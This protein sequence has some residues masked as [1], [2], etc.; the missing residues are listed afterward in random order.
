MNRAE[1]WRGLRA[2]RADP[3]GLAGRQDRRPVFAAAME[4]AEQLFKSAETVGPA[5]RPLNLFYALSQGGRALAAA[6]QADQARWR[7]QSHG[8]T[9]GP[10]RLE[11]AFADLSL[12]DQPG[13]AGSFNTVAATLGSPSLMAPTRLAEILASIPDS[14]FEAMAD[15]SPGPLRMR[16]A[17]RDSEAVLVL[18]QS[19][20]WWAEG[21]PIELGSPFETEDERLN[22][23]REH[24]AHYPSLSETSLARGGPLNSRWIGGGYAVQLEWIIEPI[25]DESVRH[26]FFHERIGWYRGDPYVFPRLPRLD[27]PLHPLVS[28]W[29]ALWGLS[30]LARYQPDRWVAQLNVDRSE[31]AVRLET[32]L[33][34]A[35]DSVPELLL[36]ALSGIRGLPVTTAN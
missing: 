16:Y 18:S 10:G 17:P 21:W 27:G 3:P 14:G 1:S 19:V 23:A 11:V 5:A 30:M 22:W 2:L 36:D 12:V 31:D 15:N 25:G 34:N 26:R 7:L 4:Q 24:L 29:A 35:L 20:M 8:I 33:D 13:R 6:Q 9:T 28:W 32:L